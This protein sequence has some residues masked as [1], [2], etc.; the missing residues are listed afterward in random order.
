LVLGVILG[1]AAGAIAGF[2]LSPRSGPENREK[3][4]EVVP[5]AP[6]AANRASEDLKARL[7]EARAAYAAGAAET[8]ARMERE[9]E[10]SRKG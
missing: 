10:N 9:L 2:L 7:E 5:G 6:E 4:V 8:R 3:L 1:A